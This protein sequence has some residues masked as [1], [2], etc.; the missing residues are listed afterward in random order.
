MNV[1]IETEAAQFLFW[2]YLNGIFVAVSRTYFQ[3]VVSLLSLEARKRIL[4]VTVLS[5][6]I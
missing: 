3:A 4:V 6:I 2:E 1:E 5:F